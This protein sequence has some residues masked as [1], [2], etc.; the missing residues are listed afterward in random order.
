MRTMLALA[1]GVHRTAYWNLAPEYPGPVD[2]HQMMH[3]MIG[4]L[5]LLGYADGKLAVRHP[6]AGTFARLA[7]Q[8]AG[9][10]AVT[11]AEDSSQPTLQA[12]EVHRAGRGP[13]LVF[14]D[15]RD[16]FHGEDEPPVTVSWPWTEGAATAVDASA[17]PWPARS[18]APRSGCRSP[19]PRSSSPGNR[20]GAHPSEPAARQTMRTAPTYTFH[21][22]GWICTT[23]PVA[24]ASS[25][26]PSPT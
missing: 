10:Q 19:P 4:K 12:F 8:L 23:W 21:I 9:A 3:L 1:S 20:Q 24:G 2:H 14:W 16:A 6:A 11:Q 18:P 25:I 26:M 17:G 5:P 7:G 15:Y 22:T 13:L